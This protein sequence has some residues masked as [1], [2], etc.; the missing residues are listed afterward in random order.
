[1]DFIYEIPNNLSDERCEEIIKRFDA[2]KR[3]SAGIVGSKGEIKSIKKSTDLSITRIGN[4]WKDI[5][6]Y[7]HT[8]LAEGIEQYTAHIKKIGCY[9]GISHSL[10]N[11][12]TDSGYQIQKSVIGDYYSWHNDSYTPHGRFLTF[13][14]YLTSH[15][16][17]EHGGGTAFHPKIDGGKIVS[18]ER[19]K[20]LLFPATW[21]YIHMGLPLIKGDPKYIAT[22]WLC[23]PST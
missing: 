23:S 2:D 11:K 12:C 4:E 18:P 9:G 8:Q 22:G 7:L 1:M 21:T 6:N 3:K 10:Q 20:L 16:P 15:D 17:M 13:L 5:D 19:G 14:W